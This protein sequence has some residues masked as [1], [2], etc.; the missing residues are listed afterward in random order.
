V[1]GNPR[2]SGYSRT[3]DDWYQETPECVDRFLAAELLI[4]DVWAPACGAGNIPKRCI[5]HG[6]DAMASDLR[7]RGYG[8]PNVDFL[9]VCRTVDNIV[10]NPPFKLAEAFV[11]HA[12]TMAKRKVA[13]VA[14]LSFLEGQSRRALFQSTPVSRIWVHSSRVSMPPGGQG[15]QAKNGSVAYCWIVWDRDWHA[16]PPLGWLP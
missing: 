16:E 2:A 5:A 13:I 12:L 1:T 15:V 7:D 11:R 10:T 8:A 9:R 14:R 4:G 6:L 3:D